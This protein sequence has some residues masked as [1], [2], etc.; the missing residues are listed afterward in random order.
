VPALALVVRSPTDSSAWDIVIL[1][2]VIGLLVVVRLAVALADASR[3]HVRLRTLAAHDPLTGLLNRREFHN[4][5]A[6]E[7]DRSQRH[8]MQFSVAMLDLDGFKAVND[9]HGHAHGDRLLEH[10]SAA[11]RDV[12]RA[13]DTAYRIGGDEF[14]LLLPQ[15]SITQ[16]DQVMDRLQAAVQAI[17]GDINV[18]YGLAEWPQSTTAETLLLHADNALY[19]S[20]RQRSS[21]EDI[22]AA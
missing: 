18:S 1:G 12:C 16:C 13:S 20:K 21:H 9:E 6:L 17:H 15:T 19:T 11:L 2:V 8:D 5:I 3:S 4:A 7:I 14:A 10:V 22:A